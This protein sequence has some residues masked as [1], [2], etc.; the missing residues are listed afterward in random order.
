MSPDSPAPTPTPV[1]GRRTVLRAV[2][3]VALAGGTTAILAACGADTGTSARSAPGGNTV[4]VSE[5]P[6]GGGTIIGGRY[7]VTQPAEG[8]FKVFSARCTHQGNPVGE[9]V[10]AQIV[11][12]FHRS[13]FS[14]TDG[15]VISGPAP[16]PLPAIAFTRSGDQIIITG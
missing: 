14:I 13:H 2:G 6:V 11:C 9:V 4:A 15:S 16:R 1:C 5:V 10:D 8:D 7:V 3:L 12:P